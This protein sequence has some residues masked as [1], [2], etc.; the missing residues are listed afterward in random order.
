[1]QVQAGNGMEVVERDLMRMSI[2]V[3]DSSRDE[4]HAGQGRVQESRAAAGARAMVADLQH[5]H[6]AQQ[7]ALSQQRLDRR[8]R[9]ARQERREPAAA[10]EA[11]HGGIVD[12]A[13]GERP[14]DIA[15][16]WVEERHRGGR[17]QAHPLSCPGGHQPTPAFHP[18]Q[19]D[20]ARIGRVLVHAAGIQDQ[21]DVVSFQSRHQPSHVVLVRM[22]QDD[23]VDPP[24]PPR[25]P[26]AEAPQ[27]EIGVRAAV[28]QHRR[29]RRCFHEDRIPLP[30]VQHDQV[31][32]AVGQAAHGQRRQQDAKSGQPDHRARQAAE[33]ATRDGHRRAYP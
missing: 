28:E 30:D 32:A 5:V 23:D 26:L 27:Q 33:T 11:D 24:L 16:R 31:Q 29:A 20:K 13:I 21:P 18:G 19:L 4:G 25:Q 2:V 14:R 8:L 15:A 7:P 10:E 17:I 6:S 3:A 22:G 1:M 12:V 9:I